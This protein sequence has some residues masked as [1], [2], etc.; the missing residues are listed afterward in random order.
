MTCRRC[1]SSLFRRFPCASMWRRSA[2]LR[3]SFPRRRCIGRKPFTR[4]KPTRSWLLRI[5]IFV[6]CW[7]LIF[8]DNLWLKVNCN[9]PL[10]GT[11]KRWKG[12]RVN[13]CV[14]PFRTSIWQAYTSISF[15]DPTKCVMSIIE[16]SM[17]SPDASKELEI[18][19]LVFTS[20]LVLS[21]F[22]GITVSSHMQSQHLRS[23][24]KKGSTSICQID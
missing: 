13:V 19:H 6:S 20:Y 8:S 22:D 2:C 15:I 21:F 10:F 12:W 7:T 5:G 1:S 23:V 18:P 11:N 16:R 3:W 14:I 4:W 24:R 9:I 17:T